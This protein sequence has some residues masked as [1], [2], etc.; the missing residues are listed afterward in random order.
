[1]RKR[2]EVESGWQNSASQVSWH[3]GE[4]LTP[5]CSLTSGSGSEGGLRAHVMSWKL[6]WASWVKGVKWPLRLIVQWKVE[7]LQ[8]IMQPGLEGRVRE[9]GG[10]GKRLFLTRGV[11]AERRGRRWV[12]QRMPGRTTMGKGESLPGRGKS[13]CESEGLGRAQFDRVHHMGS[14][15]EAEEPGET[16]LGKFLRV[17]LNCWSCFM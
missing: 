7:T 5:T 15:D 16:R 2:S 14:E 13:V 12:S 8:H 9:A 6:S 11:V 3:P 4:L 17:R 1:M 10:E